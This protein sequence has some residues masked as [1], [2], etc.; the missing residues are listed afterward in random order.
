M[1]RNV[2]CSRNNNRAV[3][4]VACDRPESDATPSRML[5]PKSMNAA[6]YDSL[7]D[8]FESEWLAGRRPLIEDYLARVESPS[9]SALLVEL[10]QIELWWRREEMPRPGAAIYRERFPSFPDAVE[11]AWVAFQSR[12]SDEVNRTTT[13]PRGRSADDS[14]SNPC[15]DPYATSSQLVPAQPPSLSTLSLKKRLVVG[16]KIGPFELNE[17]LGRGAFGEVWKAQRFGELAT[18]NVA[19]KFPVDSIS[20]SQVLRQEARSWA[21]ASGH[22][23]VLP[24]I[25]ADKYDGLVAIVSEYIADGTLADLLKRQLIH[26]NDAIEIAIGVMSG[27]EYLHAKSIIHRDLKPVNILLQHGIP[28]LADFGLALIDEARTGVAGTPAYM[29]PEAF[30]GDSSVRSD[31]W[32]AGIVL[33]EMLTRRLPFKAADS[34]E[35]IDQICN[36]HDVTIPAQL[37]EPLRQVLQR[38][39]RKPTD[40][41]YES[42]A[43]MRAALSNCRRRVSSWDSS[44]GPRMTPQ[45]LVVSV[46]GSMDAA[47]DRVRQRLNSVLPAFHAPLTSWYTGS[48]SVVD[49]EAA[50]MLTDAQQQLCIVGFSKQNRSQVVDELIE[51]HDLPFVD[52]QNES[53][54]PIDDAP[55]KRDTFFAT[56]SDLVLLFWDGESSGT[57][58]LIDWLQHIRRDHLVVYV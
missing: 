28:R 35:L 31:L 3:Y 24:I 27:L 11:S 33:Y 54:P 25:E 1:P 44:G 23:N 58:R 22:P 42:A 46:T 39:L 47:P 14:T 15:E 4:S 8:Q 19:I 20:A 12:T 49:E 55:S 7:C 37:P 38:A 40:D 16:A 43:E 51:R 30:R 45:H 5:N 52:V 26:I 50:A 13:D 10:L 34:R 9:R 21:R 2:E 53:L 18:T 56:K 17:P 48:D 6:K 41:R 36:V 32:S 57:G 29:A